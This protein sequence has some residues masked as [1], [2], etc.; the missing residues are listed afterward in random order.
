MVATRGKSVLDHIQIPFRLFIKVCP[1]LLIYPNCFAS[2]SYLLISF[3]NIV[4]L[5]RYCLLYVYIHF[6]SSLLAQVVRVN[7][8]LN[9]PNPSLL[10]PFRESHHY[11]GRS[12]FRSAVLHGSQGTEIPSSVIEPR[13]KSCRLY[14]GGHMASN[15]V[16]AILFSA[17]FAKC[18]FAQQLCDF[19]TSSA[20]HLHSSLKSIP[21]GCSAFSQSV[22]HSSFTAFAALGGLITPPEQR[23]RYF[24]LNLWPVSSHLQHILALQLTKI[25]RH[26]QR[27]QAAKRFFK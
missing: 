6:E 18:D 10:S 9:N 16:T 27:R 4:V 17:S 13:F 12:D 14:N 15:Q 2:F 26:K 19:V 7:I 1:A 11:Y 24:S 20:I 22:H 23:Y 21:D 5:D 25:S 8:H 3:G